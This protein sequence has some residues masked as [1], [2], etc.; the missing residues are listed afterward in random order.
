MISVCLP[1][2]HSVAIL[3][4]ILILG[5]RAEPDVPSVPDTHSIPSG[6]SAF[7]FVWAG[8]QDARDSDFLA[9][10]DARRSEPTYGHV[11]A[12]LPVQATGT[13]PHH[14]DYEYPANDTLFANGWVAGRTFLIDLNNPLDPKLAGE[15]TDAAGY[16]YPH[17]FAQ[18]PNGHR[19]VT[20]QSTGDRYAPPGGLV[21]LDARGRAIRSASAATPEIDSALTWPY[22]LA[23]L[24]EIDRVVTTSADMGMPPWDEWVWHDTYHV[25]V[26]SLDEL[27][28]LVSVPLPEVK[29]QRYH[30]APAEPRVLADGTVYVV[31]FSCGLYRLDGLESDRPEAT[32]V[33]AFPGG[34]L[35]SE[36]FVPVVYGDYW[37][38]TVPAL[39]GLI[40]LDVSDPDEPVEVS[41]LILDDRF[42]MPHW[43]AA[44]RAS[45]RVIVTGAGQSW[46]LM[47]DFDEE[48]GALSI[49][50]DF[51]DS[52]AEQPGVSFDRVDW[53]HGETGAAIVHGALFMPAS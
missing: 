16:R 3:L 26:W 49:D 50:G 33:H 34:E 1:S 22:S 46:V 41:R 52:G 45:G 18:L 53:P 13:M 44:D 25:Q 32:F 10:I 4:S 37:I 7:L 24:P 27:A 47:L 29:G 51:R 21:E 2:P 6:E 15:F 20:F 48:A 40:V 17:S 19:L 14:T 11:L 9:V 43:V 39:P 12:T 42:A 30:F 31:T 8:D 28:L 36:C 35:G 23:V 38:Q 5:G